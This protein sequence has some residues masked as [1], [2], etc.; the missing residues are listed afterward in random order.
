MLI[1]MDLWTRFR[2]SDVRFENPMTEFMG[3]DV[4]ILMDLVHDLEVLK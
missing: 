2:G 4:M 1:L 3:V